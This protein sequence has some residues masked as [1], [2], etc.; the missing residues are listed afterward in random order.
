MS[1]FCTLNEEFSLFISMNYQKYL[2]KQQLADDCG[3][4]AIR[5]LLALTHKDKAYLTLSVPQTCDNLAEMVRVGAT[6][7]LTLHG[8]R[9]DNYAEVSTL[10]TPFIVALQEHGVVHFVVAIMK[11]DNIHIL[12]PSGDYY[13]LPST[14]FLNER[15]T[16]VLVVKSREK[17]AAPRKYKVKLGILPFLSEFFFVVSIIVGFL[18]LGHANLDL[19]S[20]ISF[21]SAALFKILTQEFLLRSLSRYDRA[22]IADKVKDISS[23]FRTRFTALIS[24]KNTIFTRPLTLFSALLSVLLISTIFILNNL[25]YVSLI[26]FLILY[27]YVETRFTNVQRKDE[28]LLGRKISALEQTVQA[29]RRKLYLAITQDSA[30]LAKRHLYRGIIIHFVI[31]ILI[32]VLMYFSDAYTLNYFIFSFFGFSYFLS[33]VKKVL[34]LATARGSYYEALNTINDEE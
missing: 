27:A 11:K 30:R 7:G 4:N 14:V 31:A 23:D 20:Y 8:Y 13:E 2:V 17:V 34:R 25:L 12:D 5:M 15:V 1:F 16:H 18:F 22:V 19:I 24:A 33:E 21:T 29:E 10:T 6:W 9:V 26:V 32:F 28:F 3:R